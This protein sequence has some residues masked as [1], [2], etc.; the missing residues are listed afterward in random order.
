MAALVL[1]LACINLANLLMVRAAARQKEIAM[2]A[3]LGGSRG[4]LIRQLLTESFLLTCFRRAGRAAGERVDLQRSEQSETTRDSDL[5]GFH[6][7]RESVRVC[8]WRRD[9]SGADARYPARSPR[10]PRGSGDGGA[11]RRTAQFR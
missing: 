1:V 5:P 9:F 7:R 4:R 2:R 10:F 6:F 8:S 11:R 3:A